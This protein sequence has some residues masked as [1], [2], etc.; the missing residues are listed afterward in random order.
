MYYYSFTLVKVK[1]VRSLSSYKNYLDELSGTL[2]SKDVN[3]MYVVYEEEGGLHLHAMIVSRKRV[4]KSDVK[5][6]KHGWSIR[7][8]QLK[9]VGDVGGWTMYCAKHLFENVELKHHLEEM[10]TENAQEENNDGVTKC[11]PSPVSDSA[12]G[13]LSGGMSPPILELLIPEDLL[14]RNFDIRNVA[15]SIRK[16]IS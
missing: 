15:G 1:G 12:Q 2:S 13:S 7:I 8:K 3:F 5:I 9:T 4:S 6:F 11:P 16:F 14:K 10:H